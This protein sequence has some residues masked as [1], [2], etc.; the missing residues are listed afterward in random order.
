[1]KTVSVSELKAKLSQYLRDVARGNEIQ[2]IDRGVP[3][4][5]LTAIPSTGGDDEEVRQ[6]LARSG[7][8][9]LG[10]G[11]LASILNARPLSLG[12]SISRA[13][14]DDREDRI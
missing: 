4:A 11:D 5:R 12:T 7:V 3:I 9:R 1:M 2:V 14:L 10:N 8:L 13:L 6:R